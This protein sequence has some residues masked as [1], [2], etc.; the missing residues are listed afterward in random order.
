[1]LTEVLGLDRGR[2]AGWTRGRLLQNALWDITDGETAL[3][4]SSI[5]IAESLPN[6]SRP[7]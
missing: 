2:A 7:R 6:R 5:A 3:A 1:M 4:P